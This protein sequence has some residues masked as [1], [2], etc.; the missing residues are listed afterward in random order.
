MAV[1]AALGTVIGGPGFGTAIGAAIGTIA[2][3]LIGA[4]QAGKHKDQK[5]RDQMREALVNAGILDSDYKLPLADGTMYNMGRDGG[6]R[7]EFGGLRPYEIDS[8]NPLAKYAISWVNP[9][10]ELIAQGNPKLKADFVGYFTNAALT[11][12]KSL[13]DVRKNVNLFVQRFGLTDE[14]LAQAITKGAQSGALA[15]D[16][17]AAYINGIQERNNPSFMGSSDPKATAPQQVGQGQS[18]EQQ[19]PAK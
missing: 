18:V 4:I 11:N 3:G 1:G 12:A 7:A 15:P 10:V 2:G 14:S 6:P 19:E 5:V 13:D 9:L 16:V 17:A 8:S